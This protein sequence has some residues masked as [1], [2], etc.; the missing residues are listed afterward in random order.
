MKQKTK[1]NEKVPHK[2]DTY[3][4]HDAAL[5]L[6]KTLQSIIITLERSDNLD[7]KQLKE[8]FKNYISKSQS[9][10]TKHKFSALARKKNSTIDDFATFEPEIV[11]KKSVESTNSLV[12]ERLSLL[13][14]YDKPQEHIEKTKKISLAKETVQLGNL[15]DLPKFGPGFDLPKFGQGFDMPPPPPPPE[16]LNRFKKNKPKNFTITSS[17]KTTLKKNIGL[18]WSP[19]K[20]NKIITK[21]KANKGIE[22]YHC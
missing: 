10:P 2:P 12:T 11:S 3:G 9:L 8:K 4:P 14:K 21:L 18:P 13:R 7:R 5:E 19:M 22:F 20:N 1:I 17:N 6:K 16:L 15:S